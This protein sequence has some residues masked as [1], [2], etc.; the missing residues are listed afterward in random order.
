MSKQGRRGVPGACGRRRCRG[1]PGTEVDSAQAVGPNLDSVGCIIARYRCFIVCPVMN[2][3][4]S[5]FILK[6]CS[7]NEPPTMFQPIF[8]LQYSD[9]V[10]AAPYRRRCPNR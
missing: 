3:S 7:K 10:L 1:A 8:T 2:Q 4:I 5:L 9:F 6:K